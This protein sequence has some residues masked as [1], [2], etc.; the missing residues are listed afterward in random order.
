MDRD[1]RIVWRGGGRVSGKLG[2]VA[3]HGAVMFP[4]FVGLG[5]VLLVLPRKRDRPFDPWVVHMGHD[6]DIG[7]DGRAI[8]HLQSIALRRRRVRLVLGTEI[9]HVITSIRTHLHPLLDTSD[10]LLCQQTEAP[11]SINIIHQITLSD[12]GLEHRACPCL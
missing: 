12:L 4:L 5:W 2:K 10:G 3:Y 7:W 9:Y 11:M 1:T 8:Q 6:R